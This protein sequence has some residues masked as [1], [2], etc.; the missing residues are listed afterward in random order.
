MTTKNKNAANIQGI[1]FLLLA[2]FILSLQNIAVRWIGGDYSILEI[3]TLRSLVALPAAL[4]LYH[5]EGNRGFPKTKR[6]TLEIVRGVFLFLSYTTHFMGLASLP[7]AD[8]ESIR[9]SGPLLI[10][11]L[12]VAFLHE[13]VEWQRWV[14]LVVG[15]LGILI[16]VNP[17]SATFNLGSIFIIISVFFYALNVIITRKLQTTDSSATMAYFSSIVYL[18]AAVILI[19]LPNLVGN[20]DGA[21]PSF[22]F[23][24][25]SWNMPTLLD[26][27][28]MGGLGLVWAGGMYFIARAYSAGEASS[29]APFE[30]TSLLISTAWG[31]VLWGEIPMWTTILGAAITLSSGLY[32]LMRERKNA[33]E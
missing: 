3:V 20:V 11:V 27:L 1:G 4:L 15:F 14:A 22:A 33:A 17:G 30:Y 28:I 29:I 25:R 23:L 16:V 8:I 6:H 26:L 12:S 18:V 21:H 13:K 5:S 2:L 31:F 24:L 10:T 9:F 7:L 32:L 19:P